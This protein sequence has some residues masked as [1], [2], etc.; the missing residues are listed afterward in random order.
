MS[1][2]LL[3]FTL[4]SILSSA[5]I[6]R[7]SKPTF[8]LAP[9]QK[10]ISKESIISTSGGISI[11]KPDGTI[12]AKQNIISA[13]GI[14]LSGDRSALEANGIISATGDISLSGIGSYIRN[15]AKSY[16]A[17]IAGSI[18][19]S[20]VQTQIHSNEILSTSDIKILGNATSSNIYGSNITSETGSITIDSVQSSIQALTDGSFGGN[21]VNLESGVIRA[22]Q[23]LQITDKAIGS[24]IQARKIKIGAT[25]DNHGTLSGSIL[26]Q[27]NSASIYS[28]ACIVTNSIEAGD[29]SARKVY[30]IVPNKKKKA[31]I[32]KKKKKQ[33]INVKVLRT[34]AQGTITTNILIAR[35]ISA[36]TT[37]FTTQTQIAE[38]DVAQLLFGK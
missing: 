29:I 22:A 4:F 30:Q 19:L 8:L 15:Y 9:G 25:T 31:L 32:E 5:E 38:E 23:S 28:A 20:G 13:A 35:S 17:I 24:S 36:N 16:N 14:L 11:T 12:T 3:L 21:D 27:A 10:D 7:K 18:T 37:N 33:K 34:N 26:A 1:S 6:T 2:T